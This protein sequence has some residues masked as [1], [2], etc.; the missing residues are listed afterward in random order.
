[1]SR[2]VQLDILAIA[3]LVSVLYV[4]FIDIAVER[5]ERFLNLKWTVSWY[6]ARYIGIVCAILLA[7]D[8]LTN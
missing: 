4:F 2:H 7:I 6:A 3:L 5:Y 1:M 8:T